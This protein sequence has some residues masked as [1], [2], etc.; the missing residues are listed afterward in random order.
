[1]ILLC[2]IGF[3]QTLLIN[4]PKIAMSELIQM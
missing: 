1:V 4:I 2:F 3:C